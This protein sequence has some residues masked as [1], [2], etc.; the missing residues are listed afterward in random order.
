M[1]ACER[2]QTIWTQVHS[3]VTDTHSAGTVALVQS[4]ACLRV[5][6]NQRVA[7]TKIV[8]TAMHVHIRILFAKTVRRHRKTMVEHLMFLYTATR[9]SQCVASFLCC[10]VVV[11]AS[12]R[13]ESRASLSGLVWASSN[14][15][16]GR[17]AV[18]CF[19]ESVA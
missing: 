4:T 13:S 9:T 8:A 5:A 18:L 2:A 17:Q 19:S 10:I 15:G 14:V 12:R 11:G 7:C 16:T 3:T 6:L 1:E